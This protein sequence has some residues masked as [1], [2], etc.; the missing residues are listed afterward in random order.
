MSSDQDMDVSSF[1]EM[2][3]SYQISQSLVQEKCRKGRPARPFSKSSIRSQ[4]R[5]C[6]ALFA[7][8]KK[9]ASSSDE[10][11]LLLQRT[12]D[13]YKSTQI[14]YQKLLTQLE[15]IYDGYSLTHKHQIRFVLFLEHF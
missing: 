7:Y 13:Q 9:L 14:D 3:S 11:V 4:E 2:E 15:Q 10:A 12:L 1:Q 5:K 6:A 8:A